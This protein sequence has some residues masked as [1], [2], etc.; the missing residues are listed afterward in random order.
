MKLVDI[1]ARDLPIW[2]VHAETISQS[3]G[4]M[5]F[6]VPVGLKVQ[7]IHRLELADDW[8]E[9]A[10]T[11]AQWQA[12]V[13]ALQSNRSETVHIIQPKRLTISTIE[14]GLRSILLGALERGMPIKADGVEYAVISH[15]NYQFELEEIVRCAAVAAKPWNSEGLPPVGTVCE[16]WI[17]ADE[18]APCQV[19][20]M[21]EQDGQPVSV[22]RYGGGYYAGTNKCLRPIR[23]PEQIAAE[24]RQAFIFDAVLATD[25]ETPLE[26]R[27]AVFGELYDLGYRKFEIVDN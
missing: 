19:I 16:L 17:R 25:S 13:D 3:F 14:G 9:A 18:W 6:F 1:L 22:V 15:N 20:A 5:I 8:R 12:A 23:T 2:P 10:V 4:G 26:W 24:E 7:E 21:D 11:R 27:K